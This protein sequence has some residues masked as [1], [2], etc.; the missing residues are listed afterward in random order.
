MDDSARADHGH[1]AAEDLGPVC[2]SDLEL[3]GGYY[4]QEILAEWEGGVLWS[5]VCC[6][7]YIHFVGGF[8][9]VVVV[10]VVLV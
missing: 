1:A 4:V 3:N 5:A 10:V 2:S 8:C 6:V 7:V 9:V